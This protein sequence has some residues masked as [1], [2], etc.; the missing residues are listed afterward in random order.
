[1]LM[2]LVP[3]LFRSYS[4]EDLAFEIV[5]GVDGHHQPGW[6]EAEIVDVEGPI[7][8]VHDAPKKRVRKHQAECSFSFESL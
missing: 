6:V 2:L 3:M 5:R 8:E 7:R 4:W 1:M